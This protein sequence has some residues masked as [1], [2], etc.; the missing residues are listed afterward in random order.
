MKFFNDSRLKI[1][2]IKKKSLNIN[3]Q[4]NIYNNLSVFI[5]KK[6]LNSYVNFFFKNGLK[7]KIKL[8]LLK[9]FNLFFL[10]FSNNDISWDIYQKQIFIL[11]MDFF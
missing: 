11:K 3:I 6:L 10:F 4:T 5:T 2:N 7:K 8:Q 9:S 1:N